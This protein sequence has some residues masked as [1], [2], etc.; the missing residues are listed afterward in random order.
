MIEVVAISKD[1]IRKA[2]AHTVV[3]KDSVSGKSL[4]LVQ[5]IGNVVEILTLDQD[6]FETRLKDVEKLNNMRLQCP[7]S[8]HVEE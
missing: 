1:A 7:S 4:A 6:A 5:Y 8:V 2:D 3:I